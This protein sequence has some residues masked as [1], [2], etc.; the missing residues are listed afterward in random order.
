MLLRSLL[1]A[2]LLAQPVWA[3]MPDLGDLTIPRSRLADWTIKAEDYIPSTFDWT[4]Y[5][6]NVNHNTIDCADNANDD[7][8]EVQAALTALAT[9]SATPRRIMLFAPN[10]VYNVVSTFAINR[11]T[12]L[13]RGGGPTTVFKKP[14]GAGSGNNPVFQVNGAA[15]GSPLTWT[16]GFTKNTCALTLSAV[17]GL[18]AGDY[19]RM[20]ANIPPTFLDN[21]PRQSYYSFVSK[22]ASISGTVITLDI[23][24]PFDMATSAQDVTEL[25]PQRQ[26]GFENLKVQK[27]SPDGTMNFQPL[28]SL[29]SSNPANGGCA[30]CWVTGV[31][32]GPVWSHSLAGLSRG[33][34]I[35]VRGN[36]FN[37]Q[38]KTTPQVEFNKGHVLHGNDFSMSQV[39]NNAFLDSDVSIEYQ[40]ATSF[41][42]AAY[43]YQ[44]GQSGDCERALFLHNDY[45]TAILFEGNDL[46]ARIENENA[47]GGSG[48]FVT[49]FR[50]RVRSGC[51][52]WETHQGIS[53]MAFN[54]EGNANLFDLA[55]FIGN[56]TYQ[57][58]GATG[59]DNNNTNLWV[60]RNTWQCT[61]GCQGTDATKGCFLDQVAGAT[62]P[63]C[64]STGSTPTTSTIWLTNVRSNSPPSAWANTRFPKSLY[65]LSIPEWWCVESGPFPNIGAPSDTV[66]AYSKLPAQILA[67]GGTCTPIVEQCEL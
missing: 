43:N 16:A 38:L 39:E 20:R 50:N 7:S 28:I 47:N 5:D 13:L 58:S 35:L 12:L 17:T 65:Q 34:R 15:T 48:P 31:T 57:M 61:S 46:Q 40:N 6:V 25:A 44:T 27:D 21:T 55:N 23:C 33:A 8:P 36:I 64:A 10:C 26:V 60:E 63:D 59:F 14:T 19:V 32:F 62:S 22:I 54:G 51:V 56:H 24:L 49:V 29:A 9:E 42:I 66:G 1:T 30:E 67:E 37:D 45:T 18:A 53:D 2:L 41:S 52:D 3:E 11:G 4:G